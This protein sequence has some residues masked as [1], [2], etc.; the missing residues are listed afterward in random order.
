MASSTAFSPQAGSASSSETTLSSN[1]SWI[2]TH[3]HF[4]MAT[5]TLLP[6]P[7]RNSPVSGDGPVARIWENIRPEILRL[8]T[9]RKILFATLAL[10]HRQLPGT[11]PPKTVT[12]LVKSIAEKNDKW[13]FFIEDALSLLVN[14]GITDWAIEVLDSRIGKGKATTPVLANDPIFPHWTDLR[15]KVLAQL[16]ETG[17]S[18]LQVCKAG[19]D[20][21]GVEKM[22]TIMITVPNMLDKR[23]IPIIKKI[24]DILAEFPISVDVQLLQGRT[25][26]YTGSQTSLSIG[27][28]KQVVGLGASIGPEPKTGTL[29]TYISLKSEKKENFICGLT[30]YH[31]IDSPPLTSGKIAFH[32]HM[33]FL[34]TT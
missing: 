24:K 6:L 3:D 18:S 1:G 29:G 12:I 28:F 19:Y 2:E 4:R 31:V 11:E 8:L 14:I 23:W 20:I 15:K 13:L 5:A 22:V 16:G 25:F 10:V 30:N 9:N 26:L 33:P 21:E 27:D 17:W 34:L 32:Y 7:L